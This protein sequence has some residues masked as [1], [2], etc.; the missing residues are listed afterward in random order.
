MIPS[1]KIKPPF[2]IALLITPECKSILKVWLAFFCFLF[3]PFIGQAQVNVL[4]KAGH[5]MTP[6]AKWQTDRQLGFSVA[7]IP[8]SHAINRFMKDYYSE[9]IFGLRLGLTDFLEVNLNITQLPDRDRIGI[10]DRHAD[11]RLRLF[12]EKKLMPDLVLIL[13]PPGSVS[14]YLG[15]NV[16]VASKSITDTGIG[17]FDYTLGYGLPYV[18]DSYPNNRRFLGI[19]GQSYKFYSKSARN[20]RYLNGVFTALTWKPISWLG[21][22]VEYDGEDIHGGL[23]LKLK[24][25]GSIQVNAYDF[26]NLGAAFNLSFPLQF[27]SRE[28]RRYG[29]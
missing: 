29:K 23:L 3:I 10:G 5:I 20:I 7:Y 27:E 11:L 12:K 4:G 22:M 1:Q 6:S 8:Q 18:L 2:P 13:S 28:L 19:T 9:V 24:E 26:K 16:I 25:V 17:S 21:L 15:H 14:D